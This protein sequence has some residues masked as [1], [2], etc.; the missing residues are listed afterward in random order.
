MTFEVIGEPGEASPLDLVSV[1]LNE[2]AI[3][4]VLVDDQLHVVHPQTVSV[5]GESI[6]GERIYEACET[7]YV[8][9]DLTIAAGADV[10]FRAGVAVV[11]LD[12]V[13]VE[14][15]ASVTVETRPLAHCQ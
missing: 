2:G 4:A 12:D 11:F 5:F 14:P 9:P 3:G 1:D 13:A 7:V 8:G 10:T 6:T 15:T